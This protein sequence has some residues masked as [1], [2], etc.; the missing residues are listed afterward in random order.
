MLNTDIIIIDDAFGDTAFGPHLQ[1][2][3]GNINLGGFVFR[4]SQ[5]VYHAIDDIRGQIQLADSVN[6]PYG[7]YYP[8][9]PWYPVK[10]QVYRFLN[11]WQ[12]AKPSSIWPDIELAGTESKQQRTDFYEECTELL[13]SE[14]P[15]PIVVGNYTGL[16]VY[17]AYLTPSALTWLAKRPLW[18]A[19]YPVFHPSTWK[20]FNSQLK[21]LPTPAFE[22][23]SVDIWQFAGTLLTPMVPHGLDYSV[24]RRAGV[25]EHLFQG[26][27]LPPPPPPPIVETAEYM[28]ISDV[29]TVRVGP[30][31]RFDRA[32]YYL[33]KGNKKTVTRVPPSTWGFFATGRYINTS[34]KYCLKIS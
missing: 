10:A 24:I 29:L 20:Q 13:A 4:V 1:D 27:T 9:H 6:K 31:V 3:M 21:A 32:P 5:G 8:F 22:N 18:N 19:S 34:S 23:L 11:N 2:I 26:G 12:G 7:L 15:V 33:I 30:G 25:Y 28:V 17:R 14:T 16:W